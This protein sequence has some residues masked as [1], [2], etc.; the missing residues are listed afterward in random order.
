M[1]TSTWLLI[2]MFALSLA[3]CGDDKDTETDGTTTAPATTGAMTTTDA[4][5]STDPTTTTDATT[6]PTTTPP[7][8]T[9]PTTDGTTTDPDPTTTGITTDGTTTDPGTTT[10]GTT[11]EPVNLDCDSYCALYESGCKDFSEYANTEECLAQCAQWPIGL[12]GETAGDS[13]G[14]RSY[15]VGVANMANPEVHCPHAGPSGAMTCVSAD[16]PTCDDYCT[17][18]FGSCKDKL[19]LYMNMGDCMDQC[20]EWYPGM[21][22]ATAGDSIGCRE[23]HA[24][25]AMAEPMVHCPHAGPGGADVCVTAP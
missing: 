23:Y 6:M 3:A 12:P 9:P 1:R 11:G 5:T 10:D 25:V 8:T 20:I 14:C 18:Y 13:L 16:A 22:D 19:N 24:G 21:K 2:P 4:T 15:H 7:T 17:T